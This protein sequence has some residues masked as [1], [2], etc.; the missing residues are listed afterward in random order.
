M[1][2]FR[3][4]PSVAL[5]EVSS[6]FVPSALRPETQGRATPVSLSEAAQQFEAYFIGYIMGVM[7][8]TV[9]DGPF[10][11]KAAKAFYSFYDAEIGRLAAKS[12]GVGLA[13]SLESSFGSIPSGVASGEGLKSRGAATDTTSGRISEGLGAPL[14]DGRAA[15]TG[16]ILDGNF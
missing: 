11:S 7:R 15:G 2:E 3:G 6:S 16:G 13:H 4:L 1:D 12:G 5:P 8:E 9:P 10:D 14:A